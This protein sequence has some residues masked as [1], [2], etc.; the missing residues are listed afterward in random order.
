MTPPLSIREN[1]QRSYQQKWLLKNRP[2]DIERKRLY[3]KNNK[4]KVNAYRE[5]W[6]EKNALKDLAHDL[7]GRAVKKGILIRKP[8]HVCGNTPSIAH[9]EDYQKPLAVI[10]VCRFHHSEAHKKLSIPC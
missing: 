8:C 9:H 10:W 4:E 1:K 3:R 5:S 2:Y 7:V 6:R